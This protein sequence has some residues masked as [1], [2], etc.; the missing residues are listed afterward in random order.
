VPV[1]KLVACVN[2]DEDIVIEPSRICI[3]GRV[4]PFNGRAPNLPRPRP[5]E[6]FARNLR[7]CSHKRF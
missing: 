1:V 7:E 5:K 4:I 2:R 6:M 3:L